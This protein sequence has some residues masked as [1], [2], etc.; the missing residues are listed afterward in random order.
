MYQVPQ[1]HF[2]S[3]SEDI[4]DTAEFSSAENTGI[5]HDVDENR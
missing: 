4:Q 2:A 5:I 3:R 1:T